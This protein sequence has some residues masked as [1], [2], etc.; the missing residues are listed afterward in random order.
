[1]SNADDTIIIRGIV[2]KLQSHL[3]DLDVELGEEGSMQ[4]PALDAAEEILR[5]AISR[6]ERELEHIAPTPPKSAI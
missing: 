4:S 2:Q 1:M 5:D 6:L 3:A